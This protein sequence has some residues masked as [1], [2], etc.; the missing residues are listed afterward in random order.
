MFVQYNFIKPNSSYF[1]LA[2]TMR[3]T[4]YALLSAAML[5]PLGANAACQASHNLK[6]TVDIKSCTSVTFHERQYRNEP[7]FVQDINGTLL[8]VL[9][10]SITLLPLPH[11]V[12]KAVDPFWLRERFPIGVEVAV[13]LPEPAEKICQVLWEG[14]KDRVIV[15]IKTCCD[16]LPPRGICAIPR[17]HV[18]VTLEPKEQLN[19]SPSESTYTQPER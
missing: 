13:F 1:T 17:A 19:P 7:V 10:K 12:P 2:N 15:P 3:L 9:T 4:A 11:F 14:N 5:S 16:V 8:V 18:P 6:V